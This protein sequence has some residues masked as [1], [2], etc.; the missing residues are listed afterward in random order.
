[1]L[2]FDHKFKT[3]IRCK[4]F[5]PTEESKE[6]PREIDFA[7]VLNIYIFYKNIH[8]FKIKYI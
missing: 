8:I 3:K 5:D 1:M 2:T 4:R 7:K 6:L